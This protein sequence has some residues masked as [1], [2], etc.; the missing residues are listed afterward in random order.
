MQPHSSRRHLL[1]LVV[2]SP[3]TISMLILLAAAIVFIP[4]QQYFLPDLGNAGV[5]GF[6]RILPIVAVVICFDALHLRDI[7]SRETGD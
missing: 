2:R 7:A 4:V 1:S 6:F 3:M 5:V